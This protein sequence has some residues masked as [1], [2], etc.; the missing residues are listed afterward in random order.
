LYRILGRTGLRVSIA[1]LGTGG[2][3]R[4]G[5]RTHH[6][7][8]EAQRV[9]HRALALGIN[10]IDTAADYG[11]SEAMLGRALRGVP[12]DYFLLASKCAPARTDGSLLTPEELAA[13][14][15][16]SLTQLGVETLDLF[17][18]HSV[19]PETYRA[20][21]DRLYL[22][23]LRLKEQGKVR[24][25]GITEYFFA[26]PAHAMLTLA[27]QDDIW[28][29]IMVKY[30]ILNLSAERKVLPLAH[31]HNVGVLNM[32]PVR[33]KMT[34]THELEKVIG[35]WKD[36]GQIPRHALPDRAPLDFLVHD[37]VDSVI[38]AGYK[39]GIGHPAVTTVLIGTGR[40]AHLEANV[41]AVLGPTLPTADTDRIRTLFGGLADSEGDSE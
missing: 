31:A 37:G 22:A 12:R 23:A 38:S 15:E 5:Q 35:R 28:D 26:D 25:L 6:D 4:L 17:Q 2:P 21:V 13:S 14:C 9:V 19:M 8:A 40:V 39:F 18:F 16:R 11:D 24:F 27:L 20:A 10:L 1:A 3:S 34:R 7:E 32:S 41:A 36:G 33:V 30:G 29:T